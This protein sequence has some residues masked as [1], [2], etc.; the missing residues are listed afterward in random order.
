MLTDPQDLTIRTNSTSLP[1]IAIGQDGATVYADTNA[2]FALQISHQKIKG[3]GDRHT[4]K[5]TE[6]R[7]VSQFDGSVKERRASAH[8]VLTCPVEGFTSTEIGE[9]TQA[10]TSYMSQT[11]CERVLGFES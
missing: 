11:L 7:D 4:V 5:L 3:K 1:K 9:I 8:I 6:T 10:L 2:N